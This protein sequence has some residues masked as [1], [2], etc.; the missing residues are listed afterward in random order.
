[1]VKPTFNKCHQMKCHVEQ[2]LQHYFQPCGIKHVNA[3]LSKLF[4][5][6][7]KRWKP[8]FNVCHQ[9]KCHVEQNLLHHFQPCSIKHVDA[10]VSELVVNVVLKLFLAILKKVGKPTFNKCHQMKCHVKLNLWYY[11]QP[12]GIKHVDAMVSELFLTIFLKR[13]VNLHLTS[14]IR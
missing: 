3:M 2:I 1:M 11:F 4:L 13:L 6:I 9:M 8:T 14:V 12:C 5:T 7:F 10:M